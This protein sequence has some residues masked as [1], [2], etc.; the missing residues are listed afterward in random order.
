MQK[1]IGFIG[2]GNMGEAI[3]GAIL[4]AKIFT[5]T[6]VWISDINEER[7]S[8]MESIYGVQTTCDNAALF[9]RCDIIILAVKPQQM[10]DILTQ[11]APREKGAL[12][13]TKLVISIAA[14]IRIEKIEA[15]LYAALSAEERAGIPVIRV[16]PNTPALVLQGVSGM[17]ANRHATA[18]D[19][20]TARQILAAM[21][22]AVLFDEADLDA[23]TALS[24]SGPAYVFYLA[25]SMINA[26]TQLG[27]SKENA[28]ELAIGTIKGA[29]ALMEQRDES[30]EDLRR[31]VTSPGGT[32]EAAFKV[33]GKNNVRDTIV[34]AIKAAAERSKELSR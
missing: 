2:A 5:K 14:G 22:T 19:V 3:I 17:S 26:G 1:T 13:G 34:E 23:V 6:D 18:E 9:S 27:L 21:G 25:E 7:L 20:E 31:K 12:T 8:Q 28:R 24:G 4:K 33:L 30:P 11:I 29:A 10:T 32:T 16:M 15:V